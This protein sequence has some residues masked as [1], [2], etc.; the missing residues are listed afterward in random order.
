MALALAGCNTT[1]SGQ[2]ASL[3]G[4]RGA[5]V[6]FESIDG[7][8]RE[9]FDRLVQDLNT[10]ARSRQLA[11]VSRTDSSAYRVRGYL[12]AE[13]SAKQSEINWIWDVYDG[14]RQRV[15]RIAGEQTIKGTHRDAW[16]AVDGGTVQKIAQDSMGQLAAFLNSPDAMTPAAAQ[17]AYDG[18]SSPEAAGIFRIF[19]VSAVPQDGA[20]AP[21][22][23]PTG[24][25]DVPV[26][27][28]RPRAARTGGL[29]FATVGAD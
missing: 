25:E 19:P 15:L 3:S 22:A 11:V 7:P 29:A 28:D 8:P 20:I 4:A 24:E 16:Q 27:Q 6:A 17:V 1:G 18:G 10:E 14:R 13:G 9:I 21:V 12:V 5:T 23:G 26:P 2:N